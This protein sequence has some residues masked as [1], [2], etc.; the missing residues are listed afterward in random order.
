MKE[1]PVTGFAKSG[2][3]PASALRPKPKFDLHRT[4]RSLNGATAL[5]ALGISG[6]IAKSAGPPLDNKSLRPIAH[7]VNVKPPS[8]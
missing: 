2:F 8:Q 4:V 6:A 3:E 7:S 5:C 1:P